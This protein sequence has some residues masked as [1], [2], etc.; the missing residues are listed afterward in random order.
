MNQGKH[1]KTKQGTLTRAITHIPLSEGNRGKL[2]ALDT[3]WEVYQRL[4][5]QYVTYFCT[6]ILPDP[7]LDFVFD[8]ELSAR[9]QRVA[10]QQAAG[11]AQ[12]WRSNRSQAYA[13]YAQR[14]AYYESLPDAERVQ[15]KVP[16]WKAWN[17]PVLKAACIQANANVVLRVS[18][19]YDALALNPA[20]K[21]QF[22]YWLRVSTLDKGQPI[23][24]PVQLAEY[25]RQALAGLTPN[26]SLTL[27]KHK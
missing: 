21:G 9:W 19:D 11:M 25:H 20:D 13:G 2:S 12:S 23:Y 22:D 18:D 26:S 8:S 7:I 4:C 14:L 6:E 17:S 1:A 24:V 5:Q 15:R 16:L 3:L 10:V 27:N